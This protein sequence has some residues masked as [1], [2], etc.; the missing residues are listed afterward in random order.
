MARSRRSSTYKSTWRDA[1]VGAGLC[2]TGYQYGFRI[3]LVVIVSFDL[4][5][6]ASRPSKAP[7][8]D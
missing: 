7:G 5:I 2:N 8:D 4:A 3:S 1:L 6:E